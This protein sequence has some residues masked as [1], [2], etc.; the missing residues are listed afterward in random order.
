MPTLQVSD[1]SPAGANT[2]PAKHPWWRSL[3][4]FLLLSFSI[5]IYATLIRVAPKIDG[6]IIPFLQVWMVSFL[7]YFAACAFV[8]ITR[9]TTGQCHSNKKKIVKRRAFPLEG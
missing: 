8:L 4:L 3:L 6:M 9:P 1:L 5:V 2:V 7:P